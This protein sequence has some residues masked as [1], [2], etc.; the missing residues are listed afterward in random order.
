VLALAVEQAD[1]VVET[2]PRYGRTRLLQ[3]MAAQA[4]RNGH[5]PLLLARKWAA[6][7]QPYVAE[8]FQTIKREAILTA[9][10]FALNEEWQLDQAVIP[11]WR[12]KYLPWL[13]QAA[14]GAAL[15]GDFPPDL[16]DVYTG[17]P[18]DLVVRAVAFRLDLLALLQAAR[19]RRPNEE[20]EYIKLLL[21]IDN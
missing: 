17:Q 21:L 15:P 18:E 1:P 2:V 6:P 16:K 14:K 19:A 7:N 13:E 5:V 11:P 8:L 4:A 20:R 9:Q 10:R 3:E 12:W